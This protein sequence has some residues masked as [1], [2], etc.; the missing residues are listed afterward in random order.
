MYASEF[1]SSEFIMMPLRLETK[2]LLFFNLVLDES[3]GPPSHSDHFA[4]AGCPSKSVWA[5]L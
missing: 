4:K 1:S 3:D 2:L 5:L